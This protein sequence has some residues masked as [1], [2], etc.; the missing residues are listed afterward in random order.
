MRLSIVQFVAIVILILLYGGSG[1]LES[2]QLI[3]PYEI[4]Y[5]WSSKNCAGG[6]RTLGNTDVV[7]TY[8]YLCSLRDM[9]TSQNRLILTKTANNEKKSLYLTYDEDSDQEECDN[10]TRVEFS[11]EQQEHGGGECNCVE[12]CLDCQCGGI[13]E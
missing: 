6:D 8:Q 5:Q 9:Y 3:P 1:L 11:F 7:L 2:A 12:I 4:C 13:S 10:I